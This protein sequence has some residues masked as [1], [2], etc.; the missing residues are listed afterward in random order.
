MKNTY[1]PEYIIKYCNENNIHLNNDYSNIK[2]NKYTKIEGKCVINNCKN[3]FCKTIIEIKKY[4]AFC[5]ECT[6][7]N[8]NINYKKTCLKKYGVENLFQ[9]DI[10]KEK[11]VETNLFKY[12]VT[13][14]TYSNDIREKTKQKNLE[15]YGVEYTSQLPEV[16]NKKHNTMM[17]NFGVKYPLQSKICQNNFKQTCLKKYG[18]ENPQHNLEIADKTVKN[19]YRKKTYTSSSGK[20]YICQGYEP[21]ALEC[22]IEKENVN[23]NDII[24]SRKEVPT[25]WY[26][27]VKGKKSRHY[28]DIFISSQNR[29]IEVKST[30]TAKK[31]QDSIFLKQ[32]AAKE[33]GYNYEIWIYNSKGEIVEKHI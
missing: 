33:L 20:E 16:I 1:N 29:C 28:V 25:I 5:L 18:V 31:K 11:I 8:R 26:N 24:T 15:K 22:L 6:K 7:I 23:E 13:N 9:L 3:N 30:W 17:Q 10:I 32:N 19:N 2:T 27:N 12:G 14:P 4:G 21:F